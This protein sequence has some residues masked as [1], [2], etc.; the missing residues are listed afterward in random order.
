MNCKKLKK[1]TTGSKVKGNAIF[2]L[3]FQDY[4]LSINHLYQLSGN[5]I[6]KTACILGKKHTKSIHSAW[7]ENSTGVEG[8]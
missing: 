6:I 8:A 1:L 4:F 2:L 3:S 5:N 7:S